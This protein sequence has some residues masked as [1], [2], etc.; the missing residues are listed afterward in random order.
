MARQPPCSPSCPAQHLGPLGSSTVPMHG[1]VF[2]PLLAWNLKLIPLPEPV[3]WHQEGALPWDAGRLPWLGAGASS[4]TQ[5]HRWV[6]FLALLP[7]QHA[8]LRKP[9]SGVKRC[10]AFPQHPFPKRTVPIQ[11]LL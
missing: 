2:N 9:A 10:S 3:R 8:V 7:T 4:G 11:F 5:R 6:L 1:V